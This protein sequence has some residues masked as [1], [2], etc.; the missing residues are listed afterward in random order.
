MGSLSLGWD[1]PGLTAPRKPL[2]ELTRRWGLGGFQASH[3]TRVL[4]TRGEGHLGA[5]A[6][7]LELRPLPVHGEPHGKSVRPLV[8]APVRFLPGTPS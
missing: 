7:P 2:E 4:G 5:P 8:V 1:D 3:P 6:R